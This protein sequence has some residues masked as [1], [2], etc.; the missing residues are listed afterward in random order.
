MP[1]SYARMSKIPVY[2]AVMRMEDA[3][4]YA[5]SLVDKPAIEVDFVAL[6]A[7]LSLQCAK[8]GVNPAYALRMSSVEKREVTGPALIPDKLIYREDENGAPYY[9]RFTTEVIEATRNRFMQHFGNRSVT[10]QHLMPIGGA[11]VLVE[12]WLIKNSETDAAVALGFEGLPVGTWM[13]TMKVIDGDYWEKEVKTGN[14]K[15]FSIEGLFATAQVEAAL[16]GKKKKKNPESEDTAKMKRRM[17]RVFR[18]ML[19]IFDLNV[20]APATQVAEPE[21]QTKI[22]LMD[23]TVQ[24][25]EEVVAI[26]FP[27]QEPFELPVV[28]ADGNPTGARVVYIPAEAEEETETEQVEQTTETP[29]AETLAAQVAELSAK[30]LAMQKTQAQLTAQAPPL[31]KAKA[32]TAPTKTNAKPS[33]EQLLDAAFEKLKIMKK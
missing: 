6:S 19:K 5:I 1:I 33:S 12:S 27:E 21:S 16:L 30:V 22:K 24:T 15:G 29:S 13:V 14:V 3:G 2:D 26:T 23:V 28:D 9:L 7:D 10:H 25:G 18:D 31:P 8:E 17:K 32:D 4:V 11:A 20:T